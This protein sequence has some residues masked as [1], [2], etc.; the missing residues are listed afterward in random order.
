MVTKLPENITK[1][2][3]QSIQIA[4]YSFNEIELEK[5]GN[6]TGEQSPGVVEFSIKWVPRSSSDYNTPIIW[7]RDQGY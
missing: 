1:F 6:Y 7:A 3:Y 2:S 4:E 5:I